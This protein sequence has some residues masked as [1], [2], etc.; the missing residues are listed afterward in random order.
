MSSSPPSPVLTSTPGLFYGWWVVAASF[1]SLMVGINP[2]VN[3]TFG[4]FLPSLSEEFGWSRGQAA[5]GVSLAMLGFTLTQ[6]LTGRLIARYG[7]KRVILGS[8]TLFGLG[9]LSLALLVVGRWSFYTCTFLWGTVAGGTSLLPHVT[10]IA[11]WFTQR[12]GLAMG[13]ITTGVAAGGML[14]PPLAGAIITAAGWRAGFAVLGVL[15]IT[16]TI[17][18]VSW[19]TLNSPEEIGLSSN[20]SVPVVEQTSAGLCGVTATEA[21]RFLSF[22]LLMCSLFISIA[23]LQGSAVH[24][25]P[26]LTERG[27]SLTHAASI[28]SFL[29]VGIMGGMLSSGYLVDRFSAQRVALGFL[30]NAMISFLL[31][32]S[33]QQLVATA[34]VAILLGMSLG[35]T[36]Q[37]ISAVVLW[38]FGGHAFSQIYAMTM[39]AFGLGSM[40]GPLLGGW[41]HDLLGSYR[42]TPLV[43]VVGII[44]AAFLLALVRKPHVASDDVQL[45]RVVS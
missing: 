15:A 4:V 23:T 41:L 25:V 35:A 18:V 38:C 14:L 11:R 20:G 16:V 10:I 31:L 27:F 8:A 24:F 5:H 2:I 9:L 33:V 44:C 29:A 37:L 21:R 39:I 3:L 30:A 13:I 7:A 28:V 45:Q 34:A 22:W 26:L 42:H 12:R 6:S 32:W 36:V 1:L 43:Y 17:P 40:T 19:I